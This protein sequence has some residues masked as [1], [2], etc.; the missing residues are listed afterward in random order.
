MF[1]RFIS[2]GRTPP[3]LSTDV[4]RW[5]VVH[6]MVRIYYFLIKDTVNTGFTF[7]RVPDKFKEDVKL[8]L[9]DNGLDE[10]GLALSDGG[11]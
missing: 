3:P 4:H 5:R 6:G 10:N 11:E 9:R 2:L 8:L 7:D 1:R